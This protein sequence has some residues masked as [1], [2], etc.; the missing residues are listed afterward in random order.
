MR[1]S[2]CNHWEF[3]EQWSDA[4]CRGEPVDCRPVRLPHTC[5]ELPL[6]YA[7]PS[8][9]EMVCGY[10]RTLPVPDAP[11]VFLRFDGAAHQAEIYLNG[12]PAGQHQGG[13]TG[14]TIEITDLVR[15]GEENLLAVRLDTR[16]DPS[17][18]PFGFVID[19]LTYGGLYREVWLETSPQ[20]RVS[21]LFVY[22]PT[23]TEAAV[24]LTVEAPE[25]A[26]ALRVRLCSS[27]G[28]TLV[29]R[30]LPP[31]ESAECRLTLPGA[32][33][34]DT[35]HPNLYRCIA[36]LLD[37]EGQV[38]HSRETTFG[39]R[40]AVFRA[41]GFYLNGKKTFLRGLNRHQSYPYIGY[42]A[43]ESLQRQDARILKNELHCNAVRTSHYPQSQYFLDE[44]DRLGLLVFTELPGWQ[45]IG[46]AA[47]KDRACAML[48]EMLL[49]NRNHPSI[50]LWG[51][52][53]NE[54]VDDDA[55]YT[56]TNKIAHQLDP[57]RATSGV[58]YLEK[59]HLLEDVYAYNDFS[60]NGVT[61]GA[62][63]KKDVTPDMGKA[64]LIS[65]CNGHMYPTKAF[66]DGPH[67][68]E[69]ALRHVR[70]QNAAC[71]SGE[72]AGCFG[73]C[74]FDYQTHKDFGSGDRICY[75]GVLD[76][77]RNPKLAAAVYAS[78][79]D[80][81]PVLA[82]S[83]S[84]DIGDNPAGQLG[85]AYVFSNAQQVR[86]YKNDVF[87]TA[88]RQSEWT[89]LPHPPFVMD[90]TIGELLETQ[91]HFSSSK[92]AAV[93]DCLLAAGKYGLPGLP[94]A[95]KVKFGWCMLRYKMTFADGVALYGKY[96]GNW[97]GEAT[98]WRFDAVQD[99]NVV[100]SVTLCPSAKLHL[101]VKVSRTTLRE[102]DTYDMAAV[103]VRILDE[104]GTPAPYA[105]FPVQFAVEGSAALVGPQT[106]VAEGGMTGTY[107]RTVGT[108]GEAVL[109]VSAPQT[110]PVV[111]RF[112]IEKE[113]AVWN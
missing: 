54:S 35:E 64:L 46:D 98:R 77:F 17:L 87:V 41:D 91:E 103:R 49:Q 61:P 96:V 89:A 1:Y 99:G 81:D 58:R 20:S 14:F 43:P 47:W 34:W 30:Q 84:M 88:L 94:L 111:L 51:V 107:L 112:T 12:Q 59:S 90:D 53:I 60:H 4:F 76:S 74:M 13:Y 108:A 82:V 48:Q 62:K 50:I 83:S 33:P 3:T 16:E 37:A 45:H 101:E 66:D 56:R 7:D 27:A 31:A 5:R 32:A 52:R 21:E 70:V 15:R 39:F 73:W 85:T 106:A 2:L 109:T 68:Q 86:L 80:T 18:P 93:R 55:F 63:P 78:Q 67:R 8:D 95:Y 110:Q 105:Q 23:L 69:H 22:T 100:H 92:A 40:T 42:A 71:A 11:R 65:E 26:A 72:H 44:C 97:G 104:N 57:S 10:R 113:D 9:Y 75:H 19:Y 29:S 24:Q 79:G 28:E 102:K 25:Q 36:E 6:H 38:L